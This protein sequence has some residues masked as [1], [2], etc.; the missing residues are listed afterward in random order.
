[1][2]EAAAVFGPGRIFSLQTKNKEYAGCRS[3]WEDHAT[4]DRHV[5]GDDPST[6]SCIIRD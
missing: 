6:L 4:A 3:S 2:I 5:G 1:M